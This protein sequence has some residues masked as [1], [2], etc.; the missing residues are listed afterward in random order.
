M[1]FNTEFISLFFGVSQVIFESLLI[2][3]HFTLYFLA[4][5][6]HLSEFSEKNLNFL[7]LRFLISNH[8]QDRK[9]LHHSTI[10][11]EESKKYNF[12]SRTPQN[13]VLTRRTVS[14]FWP[15]RRTHN[16]NSTH[17]GKN[18]S[19]ILRKFLGGEEWRKQQTGA[20]AFSVCN[21]SLLL[22]P[23]CCITY[24]SSLS[25]PEGTTGVLVEWAR[26][27]SSIQSKF[28]SAGRAGGS[29][30]KENYTHHNKFPP[31]RACVRVACECIW[32][33]TSNLA[34]IN[35]F[36]KRNT[37]LFKG[38]GWQDDF[39]FL[40]ERCEVLRAGWKS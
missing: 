11:G 22:H 23:R 32:V 18:F 26:P 6:I 20:A 1:I 16:K 36:N 13:R 2:K 3:L 19:K 39:H 25:G 8:C 35:C 40:F 14:V 29:V 10:A 9:L 17:H 30:H 5:P 34:I 31:A 7:F 15:E 37:M 38:A 33:P 21:S 24:T 28:S 12:T 4:S 27:S